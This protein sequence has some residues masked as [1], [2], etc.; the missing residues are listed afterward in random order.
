MA[1]PWVTS[2]G[3]R[4]S[5]SAPSRTPSPLNVTGSTWAMATAGKNAIS[6]VRPMSMPSASAAV[7][8]A[9]T[10]VNW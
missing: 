1:W 6:T 3:C 9:I 2:N 10:T 8:A 4:K 7:Q 5:T